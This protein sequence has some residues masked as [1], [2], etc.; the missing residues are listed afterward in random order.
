MR[1]NVLFPKFILKNLMIFK[2]VWEFDF[3]TVFY[4]MKQNATLKKIP[5]VQLREKILS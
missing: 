2:A 5:Y 4:K 1:K 3:Y